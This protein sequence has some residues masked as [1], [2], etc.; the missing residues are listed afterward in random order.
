MVDLVQARITLFWKQIRSK[1]SF[2]YQEAIIPSEKA[3]IMIQHKMPISVA[4]KNC[5]TTMA[6]SLQMALLI[7]TIM[8][9]SK[10][11]VYVPLKSSVVATKDGK[12]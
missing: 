1:A 5:S 9:E 6:S 12:A 8:L 3:S 7:I 4:M 11:V 2:L 10:I